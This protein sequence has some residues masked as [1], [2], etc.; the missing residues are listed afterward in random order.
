M[1]EISPQQL[2]SQI[3]AMQSELH[4]PQAAQPAAGSGFGDLLKNAITEVN[5]TQQT[6]AAMKQAFETGATDASLAEVMIAS[7]K[8]DLSFRAMTEVRNKLVNAYQEI[9][10]MPV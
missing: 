9:M 4:G 8:A 10:N 6:S 5:S 3:R 2:L 1:S 7:Q